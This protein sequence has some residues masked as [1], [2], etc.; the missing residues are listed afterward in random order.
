MLYQQYGYKLDPGNVVLDMITRNSPAV[1]SQVGTTT[2]QDAASRGQGAAANGQGASSTGRSMGR[3]VASV[4]QGASSAAGLRNLV[5]Q[6]F[7]PLCIP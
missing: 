1:Q 4:G 6:T 3:G 5:T 7:S 2:T